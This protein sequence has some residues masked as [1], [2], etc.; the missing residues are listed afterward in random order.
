MKNFKIALVIIDHWKSWP[1]YDI[2]RFPDMNNDTQSFGVFL[3]RVCEIERQKGT[4]II[5]G[6]IGDTMDQ[7][8]VRDTDFTIETS[9]DLERILK[10]NEVDV[11]FYAGYHFGMCI[12]DR[13]YG[14]DFMSELVNIPMG[15]CLNLCMLNPNN[16]WYVKLKENNEVNH[17][18]YLWSNLGFEKV[19]VGVE[20]NQPYV[21]STEEYRKI[22]KTDHIN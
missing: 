22:L 10:D 2:E 4:K 9:V 6:V 7:I 11:L 8:E 21:I 18:L 3:N 12:R 17:D 20:S 15:I 16:F 14:I 13:E 5:H 19:D 1:P